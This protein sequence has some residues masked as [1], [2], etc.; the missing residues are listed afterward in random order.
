MSL[1]RKVISIGHS[2]S[3]VQMWLT[4]NPP[5]P[6]LMPTSGVTRHR[7]RIFGPGRLQYLE[8]RC[9]RGAAIEF[10]DLEEKIK[11]AKGK[12][13][14]LLQKQ[15]QSRFP[16]GRP[17]S[18]RPEPGIWQGYDK[19]KQPDPT[20]PLGSF[21]DPS[22]VIFSLSGKRL[23]LPATLKLTE[24]FRG[25]LLAACTDPI[26][27]WLSGHTQGGGPSR[28]PH[29]ALLPFPFQEVTMPMVA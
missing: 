28:K 29:V 12:E 20:P 10:M 5:L 16:T 19:R 25:A 22:L 23:S 2:A 15:Q 11:G 6:D 7:L 24:A 3:L 4:I 21:F 26:P 17:V 9:S 13:K 18:L 1:C 8:E 14:K 27:E